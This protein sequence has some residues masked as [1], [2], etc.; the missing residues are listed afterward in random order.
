[1]KKKNRNTNDDGRDELPEII[2]IRVL[3]SSDVVFVVTVRRSSELLGSCLENPLSNSILS[4][5]EFKISHR[6]A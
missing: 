3:V 2:I 4:L 1:M 6:F 5:Q